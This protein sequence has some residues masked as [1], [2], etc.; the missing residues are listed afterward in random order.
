M[1]YKVSKTAG[2]QTSLQ[3]FFQSKM[4]QDWKQKIVPQTVFLIK[5]FQQ[6]ASKIFSEL[7]Y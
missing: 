3:Q 6:P 1:S 7:L 5:S 4:N 2:L